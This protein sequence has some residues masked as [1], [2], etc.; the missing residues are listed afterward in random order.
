MQARFTGLHPWSAPGDHIELYVGDG[1]ID[2]H[3]DCSLL[4]LTLTGHPKTV[5]RLEF[6]HVTAGRFLL[7]F[8]DVGELVLLQD[9]VSSDCW[10]EPPEKEPEGID[11]VRYYEYGAELPPVFEI[12]SLTLQCKFRAWEVSFR[13][14]VG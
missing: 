9:A 10:S 1:Y 6:Q 8:H 4:D 5:L 11:Q 13:F 14:L 7:E 12:Q 3:N 2:L